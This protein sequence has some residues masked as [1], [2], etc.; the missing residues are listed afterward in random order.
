VFAGLEQADDDAIRVLHRRD[1]PPAATGTAP[2]G[3]YV[4]RTDFHVLGLP[5]VEDRFIVA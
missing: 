4:L 5:N 3:E 1:Q 2:K